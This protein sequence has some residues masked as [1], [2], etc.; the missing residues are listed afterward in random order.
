MPRRPGRVLVVGSVNVDLVVSAATLPGPGE[1]VTGG[2]YAR[3]PGGKGANQAVAAARAGA[4][5][6]FIGAVGDDDLGR[7]AT[8]DLVREDVDTTGLAT[9]A[10]APTGVALVVVDDAG[11]NQIAVASGANAHVDVA[12]GLA[13][14]PVAQD[15]LLLG[16]EVPAEAV[17]LAAEAAMQRGWRVVCDPAPPR[18]LGPALLRARPILTPNEREAAALTGGLEAAEAAQALAERTQA[19]VVVTRGDRPAVICADGEVREV[20]APHV[21]AVDSTGAGDAFA[22]ILA[23]LLAEEVELEEAV[24]IAVAGASRSTATAG[25]REGMPTRKQLEGLE[26]VREGRR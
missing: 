24:R 25:A 7:S 3:H 14:V 16:F 19:P 15:V 21:D 4:H 5:V 17:E 22:G 11:Q 12:A 8:E 26:D 6:S 2:R 23:A 13:R 18:E 9:V 1:T 10:E 20:P